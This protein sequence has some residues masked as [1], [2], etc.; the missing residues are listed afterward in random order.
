MRQYIPSSITTAVKKGFSG[1]D[2]SWFKGESIEFV[3]KTVMNP[4]AKIYDYLDRSVV[5]ELVSEHLKGASNHRL[6][7]WALLSVEEWLDQM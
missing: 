1:P 6:L 4:K 5:K 2:A 3:K 7:I